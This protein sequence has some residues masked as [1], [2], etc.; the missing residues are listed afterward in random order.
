MIRS[1]SY[2]IV[3]FSGDIINF[4]GTKFFINIY[5]AMNYSLQ[6]SFTGIA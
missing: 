3:V 1:K 4:C 2:H 5:F 6:N